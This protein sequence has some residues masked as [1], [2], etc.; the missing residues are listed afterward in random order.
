MGRRYEELIYR[1]IQRPRQIWAWGIIFLVAL[2]MWYAFIQQIFIGTP[3]GNNPAPDVILIV[4]WLIFGIIFPILMAG[5]MKLIIEVRFDGIYIRFSPFHL[6]FRKYLLKDIKQFK[7]IHYNSLEFG[8]WGIRVNSKGEKAYSMGGENAIIFILSK[9]TVV[10][11]TKNPDELEH[12]INSIK[13][14]IRPRT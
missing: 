9:E 4:L 5:F 10:L 11:G 7:A 2:F 12:A 14:T 13:T 8:G 3:I 1:E 6:N